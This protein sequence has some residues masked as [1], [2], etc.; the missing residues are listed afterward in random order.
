M[1]QLSLTLSFLGSPRQIHYSGVVNCWEVGSDSFAAR[2]TM[3]YT[4]LM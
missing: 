3:V 4:Y 1:Y 2:V